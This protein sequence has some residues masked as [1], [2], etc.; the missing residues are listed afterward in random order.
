MEPEFS[1]MACRDG[2]VS[3]NIV[4]HPGRRSGQDDEQKIQEN[5]HVLV[6][7]SGSNRPI[8]ISAR[9]FV[10]CDVLVVWDSAVGLGKFV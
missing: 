3:S 7:I 9:Q 1:K 2:S 5:F 8:A 4:L 6:N 10:H